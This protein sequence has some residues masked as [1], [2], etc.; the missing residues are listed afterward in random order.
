MKLLIAVLLGIAVMFS[1]IILPTFQPGLLTALD[2]VFCAATETLIADPQTVTGRGGGQG[3]VVY[4][5]CV[6]GESVREITGLVTG[7]GVALGLGVILGG[8]Y[9]INRPRQGD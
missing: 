7:V 1:L 6:G 5:A 4:Y 2:A 8:N 9:I 3:L